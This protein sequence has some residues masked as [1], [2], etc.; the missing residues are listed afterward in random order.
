MLRWDDQNNHLFVCLGGLPCHRDLVDHDEHVVRHH[1]LFI[2]FCS[3]LFTFSFFCSI[4]CFL[5]CCF[6]CLIVSLFISL[7]FSLFVLYTFPFSVANPLLSQG[8]S[9]QTKKSF[10]IKN[11]V[12]AMKQ[13]SPHSKQIT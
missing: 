1:L 9:N 11:P 3:C 13:S 2:C 8:A 12:L 6:F 5:F 10:Q 7:L 4:S